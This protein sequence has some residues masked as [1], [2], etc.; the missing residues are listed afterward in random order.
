MEDIFFRSECERYAFKYLSSKAKKLGLKGKFYP[1]IK[2]ENNKIK[3]RHRNF[4]NQVIPINNEPIT[5]Y[6]DTQI[7]N[8][9]IF[10]DYKKEL[11]EFDFSK[12]S[13]EFDMVYVEKNVI[14]AAIEINGS[15]HYKIDD[16]YNTEYIDFIN[17]KLNDYGKEEY[18]KIEKIPFFE[19]RLI[20]GETINDKDLDMIIQQLS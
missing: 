11:K 12:L 19:I 17:V 4:F 10:W 9:G 3:F 13:F 5:N 18:C 20:N 1:N 8:N 16:Y 2:P 7:K 14:M 6:L 15:H